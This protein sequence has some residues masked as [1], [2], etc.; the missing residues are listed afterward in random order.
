MMINGHKI[1]SSAAFCRCGLTVRFKLVNA[2]DNSK[3]LRAQKK[4]SGYQALSSP[5]LF[6]QFQSPSFTRQYGEKYSFRNVTS[7]SIQNVNPAKPRPPLSN[8]AIIRDQITLHLILIT[9][10]RLI[11]ARYESSEKKIVERIV[12]NDIAR[13]GVLDLL[14]SLSFYI[15]FYRVRIGVVASNTPYHVSE[16][17]F[18]AHYCIAC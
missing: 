8:T 5:L 18:N 15:Y 9:Q 2:G 7:R 13:S 10:N 4:S 11:K 14:E 3:F 1:S 12:C 16:S 6:L 17:A